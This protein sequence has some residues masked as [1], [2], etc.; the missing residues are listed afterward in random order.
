MKNKIIVGALALLPMLYVNALESVAISPVGS[1]ATVSSR[2]CILDMGFRC[3]IMGK[4][5]QKVLGLYSISDA[6]D[7]SPWHV[8]LY[9]DLASKAGYLPWGY[10]NAYDGSFR[11]AR[12]GDS[13]NSTHPFRIQQNGDVVIGDVN[14][15]RGIIVD[16]IRFCP[17]TV[18][19]SLVLAQC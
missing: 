13:N 12:P 19:G 2:D 7:S 9:N 17:K 14:L 16:G 8:L 1:N 11:I 10:Q 3:A 18:A 4:A 15:K 5:G 6:V